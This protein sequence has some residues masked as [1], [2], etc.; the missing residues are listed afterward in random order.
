MKTTTTLFFTLLLLSFNGNAQLIKKNFFVS[1]GGYV[2]KE[3]KIY[4]AYALDSASYSNSS[5]NGDLYYALNY[6]LADNFSIGISGHVTDPNNVA[7]SRNAFGPTIRFYPSIKKTT[8]IK[9]VFVKDTLVQSSK[10]NHYLRK[11]EDYRPTQKK[12]QE[13]SDSISKE[14]NKLPFL[15]TFFYIEPSVLFG[16]ANFGGNKIT[17]IEYALFLGLTLRAPTKIK[18]VRR[19]GFDLGIGAR[20]LI[21][22]KNSYNFMPSI[23]AGFNFYFDK[24]YT[25]SF[26]EK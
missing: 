2:P 3:K 20:Y 10:I 1:V 9:T 5:I 8:Q 13:Y 25:R 16:S 26:I 17:N 24:Q 22:D 19:L 15:N 18:F 6:A 4:E 7:Y 23:R 21:D 11:R 14:I 12:Y